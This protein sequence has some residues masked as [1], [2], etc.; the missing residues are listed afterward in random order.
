LGILIG[1]TG[2]LVV[3]ALGLVA[4][5]S[6]E[7]IGDPAV[8]KDRDGFIDKQ[9]GGDDCDDSNKNIHPGATEVCNGKNDNCDGQTDEGVLNAC[10]KCGPTPEEICD[11]IDNNCNGLLDCQDLSCSGN[12]VCQQGTCGGV[13]CQSNYTCSNNFCTLCID[14]D[15]DNYNGSAIGD[16]SAC[17]INDCNDN[18]LIINPS[19]VEVC[20][21]GVDDNCNGLTDCADS[22]CAAICCGSSVC[23]SGYTCSNNLCTLCIDNDSDYYDGSAI[24]DQAF[25]GLPSIW[26]DCNDNNPYINPGRTENCTNEIDDNCNGAVDCEDW[27]CDLHSI[28]CGGGSPPEPI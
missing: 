2:G 26:Q 16:Q 15:G 17:N 8:D 21:N 18:N 24:G 28:S 5:N 27:Y 12:A 9:F 22:A 13:V 10:E 14:S 3:V 20:T 7:K 23:Q 6:L 19:V 4:C 1:G 25:C 11:G